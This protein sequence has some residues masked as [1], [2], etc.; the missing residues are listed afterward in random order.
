VNSLFASTDGYFIRQ[1]EVGTVQLNN[2]NIGRD[3]YSGNY[4]KVYC[5]ASPAV[6]QITVD[7]KNTNMWGQGSDASQ[8]VVA[9]GT[10][11]VML[12]T[13][14]LVI[15]DNADSHLR[16]LTPQRIDYNLTRGLQVG[17]IDALK[18]PGVDQGAYVILANPG[19]DTTGARGI[20]YQDGP[21]PKWYLYQVASAGDILFLRDITNARMHATF[22]QGATLA[23]AITELNSELKLL[24]ALNHDGTTVGFYGSTPVTKPTVTGSR[25]GNAALA[26]LLT[27]LASQGLITD[28]STV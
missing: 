1:Q 9:S 23:A 16:H 12:N 26:S 11:Q 19:D 5:S 15:T 4:Q 7:I 27:Q 13:S 17:S 14:G 8:F 10:T 20:I 6:G 24:G 22:T 21:D 2:C 25:A 18:Q 3:T 28:S